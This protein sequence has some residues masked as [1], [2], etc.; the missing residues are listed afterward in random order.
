MQQCLI[1]G[2]PIEEVLS[3]VRQRDSLKARLYWD[4]SWVKKGKGG[5]NG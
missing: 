1:W 3:C 2:C 5:E 4:G